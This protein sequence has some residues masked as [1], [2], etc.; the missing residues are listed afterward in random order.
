MPTTTPPSTPSPVEPKAQPTPAPS[1][2][3]IPTVP[4][5]IAPASTG[6]KGGRVAACI[7]R[8]NTKSAAMFV[9]ERSGVAK[10]FWGE[11]VSGRLA[12]RIV[13]GPAALGLVSE[14]CH[15][16]AGTG[17]GARVC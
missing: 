9:T 15:L 1:A 16:S 4:A 14:D 8:E 5:R 12:E 3:H 10:P 2:A 6:W 13:P 7:R 17:L 11:F